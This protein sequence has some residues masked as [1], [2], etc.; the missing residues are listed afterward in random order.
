MMTLV[1]ASSAKKAKTAAFLLCGALL[2]VAPAVQGE[3]AAPLSVQEAQIWRQHGFNAEDA[4]EWKHVGFSPAEARLW[5][6]A[7]IPYAQ[8]ADQWRGEGFGPS[9]AKEWVTK[10]INVYTAGDFRKFGFSNREALDWIDNGIRSGLRA[11]EFRDGGFV[12]AQAGLWWKRH[13]FPE[14]A[15]LWR[16]AGFGVEEA[17]EWKYGRKKTYYMRSGVKGYSRP[18]YSVEWA[19]QWRGA[20][21]SSAEAKQCLNFHMGLDEAVRW[22]KAGFGIEDAFQWKDSGFGPEEARQ[23]RTAGLTPVEAEEERDGALQK[24]GDEI[25]SFQSDII[26]HSDST[27]TVTETIAVQDGPGGVIQGCFKRRYPGQAML[28]HNGDS[29]R[30]TTPSYRFLAVMKDGNPVRY[31]TEK[32]SRGGQTICIG[33]QDGAPEAGAHVFTIQYKTDSRLVEMHDH[34]RL[35]FDVTGQPL[36]M[37]VKKASA[38]VHLPKGADLIFADGYAGPRERKY[39]TAQVEEADGSD[40]VQ[41]AVTRPLKGEMAFQVSVAYPKG[42]ARPGLMQRVAHVDRRAGHLLSAIA[43]FMVGLLIVL[44]YFITVWRR[45]GKDPERGPTAPQVGPPEGISPAMIRYI[46]TGGKFDEGTVS[47]TLVSLAQCG[48]IK[49]AMEENRYRITRTGDPPALCLP[50]EKAFLDRVFAQSD[51]F[52]VGVKRA[53]KALRSMTGSLKDM[54][55][56]EYKKYFVTNSHYLW[57]MLALSILAAVGGLF[58]LD[59]PIRG[60][61]SVPLLVYF[62]S[63]FIILGIL[64]G[65]FYRLLKA[66]TQAGRKIMDRI[67]GFR[68]FLAINYEEAR[69]F[70]KRPETDAPP[71]LEK[72]L[73]YAI[74]LDIDSEYVSIRARNLEWYGGRSGSFSPYDFTSSLKM[75]KPAMGK[76]SRL[77][78]RQGGGAGL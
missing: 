66:P 43:I 29:I 41:Y 26:L 61:G 21:F 62:G 57:R 33:V 24:P 35:F 2:F 19:R 52:V 37:P 38:T 18:V 75:K 70:G 28:R 14:D 47:A 77:I 23:K 76:Q 54:L 5:V 30:T 7:G 11:K 44:A 64:L 40:H 53:R 36:E 22:K 68:K 73:P 34:D 13:F 48:A 6:Q 20:G 42:A 17:I 4:A 39:F 10:K 46:I 50:E 49:I 1:S 51:S 58:L 78:K 16:N 59:L 8:W 74:A 65:V 71:F 9:E 55:E 69:P 60:R 15:K 56:R 72:H 25:L 31:S 63:A 3:K 32:D 67:E 12:A 45:V 27:L